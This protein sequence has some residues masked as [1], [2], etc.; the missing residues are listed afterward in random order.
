M[1]SRARS[2]TLL[3]LFTCDAGMDRPLKENN[4]KLRWQDQT[5]PNR[6][7]DRGI[8]W[9]SCRNNWTLLE[10]FTSNTQPGQH[11]SG[12]KSF[13]SPPCTCTLPLQF[14]Y[15]HQHHHT[16]HRF[17]SPFCTTKCLCVY[18]LCENTFSHNVLDSVLAGYPVSPSFFRAGDDSRVEPH[19][20]DITTDECM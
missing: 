16:H 15:F 10:H 11:S 18:M 9:V 2:C 3:W 14:P 1:C 6:S 12:G 17:S 19:R 4:F 20:H 5:W 13:I 8:D 7:D